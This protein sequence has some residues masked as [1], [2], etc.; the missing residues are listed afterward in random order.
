MSLR[1]V[2]GRTALEPGRR[3]LLRGFSLSAS[4]FC[5][6][7][8]RV[9]P[10]ELGLAVAGARMRRGIEKPVARHGPVL[11]RASNPVV[12]DRLA[13]G[14]VDELHA[15]AP[16]DQVPAGCPIPVAPV[17]R[18]AHLEELLVRGAPPLDLAG[19]RIASRGDAGLGGHHQLSR[20][21]QAVRHQHVDRGVEALAARAAPEPLA[22]VRRKGHQLAQ[23][24]VAPGSLVNAAGFP[25]HLARR[26]TIGRKDHVAVN[27]QGRGREA[28]PR[29]ADRPGRAPR[30]LA[31]PG[32]QAE[33]LLGVLE[34]DAAPVRRQRRGHQPCRVGVGLLP[35][36]LP[37]L[38]PDHQDAPLSGRRLGTPAPGGLRCAGVAGDQ[39]EHTVVVQDFGRARGPL[40]GL[41]RFAR[42][43]VQCAKRLAVAEGDVHA[44]AGGDQPS[45][46]L[47]RAAAKALQVPLPRP[48]RPLPQDH[49]VEGVP[50]D[51]EPPGGQHD[52]S[53]GPLI[54]DGKH[55]PTGRDHHADAPQALVVARAPRLA[56]PL[57][58]ARRS[59]HRV[60]GDRVVVRAVQVVCPLVNLLRAGFDGLLPRI[61]LLDV[62]HA[63]RTQHAQHLSRRHLAGVLR[64]Q[65]IDQVVGIRQP[66][67][68]P[69]LHRHL[70]VEAQRPDQPAGLAHALG[71]GLQAVNQVAI[72]R[73]QRRRH[74]AV[75]TAQVNDQAAL[76]AGGLQNPPRRL[77]IGTL[78]IGT[79]S[80]RIGG[81]GAC[82]PDE[83][84]RRRKNTHTQKA[85][86]SHDAQHDPS[87]FSSVHSKGG[88]SPI[89]CSLVID[90]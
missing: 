3:G 21:Q 39:E 82:R 71:V 85:G 23:G 31:R 72:A 80:G 48:D 32:V 28:R 22:G 10:V 13:G 61:P 86:T 69:M 18:H 68:G 37:G 34:E 60:P 89:L 45:P 63:A 47:G 90:K 70:A 59:D 62:G 27:H 8:Q 17:V 40:V 64:D 65:E 14:H 76:D 33:H 38:G 30:F 25:L 26:R 44:V 83:Q 29:D 2:I 20:P 19:C 81:A 52:R 88:Q 12:G 42:R 84:R 57:D 24:G 6:R 7:C 1:G 55:P 43:R 16:E 77:A 36:Q 41:D 79:L 15:R 75:P 49:A 56:H 50:G 9:E 78:G 87:P 54:L 46:N 4:R 74:P 11:A 53:D 73:P 58:A 66:L 51:Q 67:A 5:C 35:Q